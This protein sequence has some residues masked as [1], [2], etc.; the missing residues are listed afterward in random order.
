[1]ID[2]DVLN[3][4]TLPGGF[5]YI[6][7]GLILQTDGE[8]ELAGVLARG[9]A[10]TAIRSSTREATKS[11]LMQLASIPSMIFIP[12]S[13]ASYA[14]YQDLDL[15]IPL[16]YLKYS[17]DTQSAA[18]YFGLQYLYKA[19]YDPESYTL[20]LARVWPQTQ[21][22]KNISKV[23]SPFPP[24]SERLQRLNKETASILPQRDGAIVSTSEFQ[25]VKERLC[26]WNLRKVLNQRPETDP[27][28]ADGQSRR[29]AT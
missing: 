22:G 14:M 29:R 15:V 9:I 25:E 8:A 2:S 5:Q 11:E 18:D 3:A 19:G 21:K 28:E 1:V 16:T 7:S 26:E 6:N 4:F 17:R 13:I 10:H 12:Y 23:F 20:F 27:S 24:L